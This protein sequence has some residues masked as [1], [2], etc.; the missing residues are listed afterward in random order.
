M[1]DVGAIW[2]GGVV[3]SGLTLGWVVQ[4]GLTLGW[5]WGAPVLLP[6]QSKRKVR[7][8]DIAVKIVE[9]WA[10]VC[11]GVG[12]VGNTCRC[13]VPMRIDGCH[14]SFVVSGPRGLAL[15]VCSRLSR[16]CRR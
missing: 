16:G 6:R 15:P 14:A 5:G 13:T 3:Q 7:V 1:R 12:R 8:R 10:R 2:C 9:A 4:S 11:A